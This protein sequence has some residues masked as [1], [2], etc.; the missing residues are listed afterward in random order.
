MLRDT[1]DE[2]YQSH[3]TKWANSKLQAEGFNM[4]LNSFDFVYWLQ[5]MGDIFKATDVLYE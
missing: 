1:F 3:D 4:K 2:I 5:A